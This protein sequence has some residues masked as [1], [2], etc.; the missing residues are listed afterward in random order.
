MVLEL[1]QARREAYRDVYQ[2][3]KGQEK[4]L[5]TTYFDSIWY[6]LDIITGLPVQGLHVD[7]VEGDD[8]LSDLHRKLPSE[9]VLSACVINGRNVWR[10]FA[11]LV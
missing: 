5:M 2:V 7:L 1:P 11:E 8:E 9:W 6:Q 4:M 10:R 3:L